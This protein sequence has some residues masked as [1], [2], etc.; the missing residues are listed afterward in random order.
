MMRYDATCK[1][2]K[3]HPDD[4]VAGRDDDGDDADTADFVDAV[5]DVVRR[6]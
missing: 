3:Q 2:M 1:M 6:T 5:G 4:D